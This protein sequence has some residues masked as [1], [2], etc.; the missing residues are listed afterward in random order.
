MKDTVYSIVDRITGLF[1]REMN[2][3]WKHDHTF[4]RTDPDSL[5]DVFHGMLDHSDE[6]A[7]DAHYAAMYLYWLWCREV[8]DVHP[9]I[10]ES[11]VRMQSD[12]PVPPGVLRNI[13]H[14]NPMFVMPEG[15]PVT[16][17]DGTGGKIRGFFL[18]GALSVD[19]DIPTVDG[20]PGMRMVDPDTQ[21]QYNT[22]NVT[23][24]AHTTSNFANVFH[25]V[26]F[27]ED[28]DRRTWDMCKIMV[29]LY[30]EITVDDMIERMISMAEAFPKKP[31][32]TDASRRAYVK[33]IGTAV[34]S[35]LL[36]AAS[37]TVE[38]SSA[39]AHRAVPDP[40]RR[41]WEPKPKSSK[42][43]RVGYRTGSVIEDSLRPAREHRTSS[44][45]NGR[46]M[47]PHTRRPHMHM[48]R[49]GPGRKEVEFKL[50]GLI[51]VN[52]DDGGARETTVH[53][54]R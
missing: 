16:F 30:Q 27:S 26:V 6:K 33:D 35:H 7:A 15:V 22:G 21:R 25:V 1:Q 5:K 43:M 9:R 40:G 20:T 14:V 37:R 32:E 52:M 23:T 19:Y 10:T 13:R 4:L 29:P 11:L 42:V 46:T 36:Y 54:V 17:P 18:T 48:Y 2:Y 34:L 39:K 49:V 47:P 41:S 38:I 3:V 53:P 44:G 45:T 51:R 31:G 50:L 8:Y 12:T 28:D 24:F